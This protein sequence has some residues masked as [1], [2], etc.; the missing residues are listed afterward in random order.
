MKIAINE[1]LDAW[2]K[3]IQG[4]EAISIGKQG[5]HQA[6]VNLNAQA[7]VAAASLSLEAEPAAFVA[8]LERLAPPPDDPAHD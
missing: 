7:R 1:L 3:E 6:V 5:L 8:L 4:I 2:A